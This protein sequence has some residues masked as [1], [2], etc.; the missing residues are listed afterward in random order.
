[1]KLPTFEQMLAT[2]AIVAQSS[3]FGLLGTKR[4]GSSSAANTLFVIGFNYEGE[5]NA[6][7]PMAFLLENPDLLKQ[8]CQVGLVL[9]RPEQRDVTANMNRIPQSPDLSVWEYERMQCMAEMFARYPDAKIIDL[10][11][12]S[13]PEGF[14]WTLDMSGPRANLDRFSAMI[15]CPIRITGLC[16]VQK[17]W[18][19]TVPLCYK[20][21]GTITEV[22]MQPHN[23]PGGIENATRLVLST[24]AG[25]GALRGEFTSRQAVQLVYQ[26][27]GA[28]ARDPALSYKIEPA[29]LQPFA[30]VK[31]GQLIAVASDGTELRAQND[32]YLVLGPS[33]LNVAPGGSDPLFYLLFKEQFC[34]VVRTIVEPDWALQLS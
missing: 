10:Q 9:A 33:R 14:G 26:A 30:P 21:A 7:A 22:L 29:L 20:F 5:E 16:D 11:A 13:Q 3:D 31:Q 8:D 1:M 2:R 32:C 19:K 15:P 12:N 34:N 23:A 25:L 24:L 4:I 6:L 18:T 27:Y 28:L 17:I